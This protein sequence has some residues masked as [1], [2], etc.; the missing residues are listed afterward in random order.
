MDQQQ[1]DK[2]AKWL[3]ICGFIFVAVVMIGG[4]IFSF[5]NLAKKP[6]GPN[7][8]KHWITPDQPGSP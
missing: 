8:N 7:E 6:L 4:I 1:V 5:T 3:R 2:I